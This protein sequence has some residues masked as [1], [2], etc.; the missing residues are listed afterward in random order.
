VFNVDGRKHYLSPHRL[1]WETFVGPIPDGLQIN[2]KNGDKRD[3][4]LENLEACT[5]QENTA[6]AYS[7]LGRVR[8]KPPHKAR[9]TNGRAKLKESDIPVIR[10]LRSEGWSQQ[11]IANEFG[12]DQTLI[13]GVLRGLYWN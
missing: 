9:E 12:V 4:R 13:S 2:H 7:Q 3:N 10:G 1:T 11:R 6:H 8:A 5:P